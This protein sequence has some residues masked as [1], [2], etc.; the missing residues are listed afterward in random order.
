MKVLITG[1][2]QGIGKAIAEAFVKRGDEVIVHC[3]TDIEK[4]ERIRKEIG[5]AHAV[6]ADLSDYKQTIALYDKTGA[7]DCLILN[8]S[9]Q[10][11]NHWTKVSEEEFDKQ[12]TVNFKSLFIMMQKYV[13]DMIDRGFGRVVTIGSVNQF[14]NHPELTVYSATKCAVESLVRNIAKQVAPY[15]VTVN[16]VAPGAILTPRNQSVY[17]D[18]AARKKVENSIPLG[19]F[20]TVE[21]VVGTVMLLCGEEGSY[22]TG[23]DISV[24]GGMRL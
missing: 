17:D 20:G 7:V 23:A 22:I 5:A 3:A 6:V 16:N 9:V 24:D 2:T 14:R 10:Y 13:P 11:K 15:G 1:S 4:A 18:N 21:E 12:I 8:A 19:R